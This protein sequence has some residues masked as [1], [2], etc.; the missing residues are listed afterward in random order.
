MTI[1][2]LLDITISRNASDLHLLVGH[3]PALRLFGDLVAIQGM[4]V[5]TEQDV[6]ALLIPILTSDQK[7]VLV[8]D[9]ELDFG[10]EFEKK[11]RFR[12]NLYR[13]SRSL[14]A[15][16]RLIPKDIKTLE[17][18]GL[19]KNL[20]RLTEIKQGLVLVTGPTGQGKT[21]TLAGFI[22][23][24]NLSRAAHIITIEDP[25]EF[26]YPAGKSLIS[27]RELNLDTRSWGNALRAALR[28]DPDVVLIGEIRDLDTMSAA[29]TIAETGHLVF[30]TLHTNSASQTIDRMI[31]I[32]PTNQQSQVRSQ[33][34][35][36]IEAVISQRL[37][38]TINPG[39]VL[40]AEILF[41]TPA[42]SS[43]IRDQKTY[44][45]D[46]L[47]QTSAEQG[48]KNMESSLAGLVHEGKISIEIA[49]QYAPRPELL[50]KLLGASNFK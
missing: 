32:F 17:E 38:P 33:L 41:S 20:S 24:I 35:A 11:A 10:L 49:W 23:Q 30:A 46:N 28:E 13:Q 48:M 18:I 1:Q 39:R 50:N 9:W 45:I 4:P 14:A 47:I 42:L 26:V 36:V 6:E 34:A 3:P 8:K 5:L 2:Q 44:L 19:P 25:I 21:T 27:Q 7:D 29:M 22:N 12:V 16:F 15:A 37:V 40:A 31:D 43:L